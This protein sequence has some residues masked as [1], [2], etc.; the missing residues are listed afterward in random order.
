MNIEFRKVRPNAVTP[1]YATDG[2]A[3]LDMC[4]A[5][6][7]PVT[8]YPRQSYLFPS[9]IAVHIDN[10]EV[11]GLLFPRSGLGA[12]HG[13]QLR[14]TVGVIDSSFSQEIGICLYNS[15]TV[16]Y[17]V[18]PGDRVCQLVLVPVIMANL[19][20]VEQFT[21]HSDRGGFG[22]TGLHALD[23]MLQDDLPV[24]KPVSAKKR[25]SRRNWGK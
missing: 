3:G 9:G 11:V 19:T 23:Q 20:E 2:S 14:N 24:A 17:T 22:S 1:R 21:V 4:V 6:T 15:S 8:L 18:N 7:G 12:K 16:P 5:T 13:L 10:V 25:F